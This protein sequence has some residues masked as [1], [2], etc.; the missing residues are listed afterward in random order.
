MVIIIFPYAFIPDCTV[1]VE[2]RAP[3]P[4]KQYHVQDECQ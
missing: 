3:G 2:Q 1:V 4:G